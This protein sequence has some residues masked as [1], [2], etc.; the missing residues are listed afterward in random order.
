ML[1]VLPAAAAAAAAAL[2]CQNPSATC[3]AFPRLPGD[4]YQPHT[5]FTVLHIHQHGRLLICCCILR[6]QMTRRP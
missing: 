4:V 6:A 3:D 2:H 1:E 5:G